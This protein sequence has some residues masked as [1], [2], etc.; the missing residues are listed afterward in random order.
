MPT[1]GV[2]WKNRLV[3]QCLRPSVYTM[4]E[5]AKLCPEITRKSAKILLK[6]IEFLKNYAVLV[7][8]FPADTYYLRFC[9]AYQWG[10]SILAD[11]S[12]A[13]AA[14]LR[15]TPHLWC[16]YWVKSAWLRM[17]LFICWWRFGWHSCASADSSCGISWI[18]ISISQTSQIGNRNNFTHQKKPVFLNQIMTFIGLLIE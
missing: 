6:Y 17:P 11:S 9:W 1:N 3:F 2:A 10:L 8:N 5:I 12:L 15:L 14:V 16:K 18:Q 4:T 7:S 13:D